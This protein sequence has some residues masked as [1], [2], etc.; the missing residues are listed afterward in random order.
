M[1]SLGAN[2][3][4]KDGS[5]MQANTEV[6]AGARSH[7]LANPRPHSVLINTA[8]DLGATSCRSVRGAI[9]ASAFTNRWPPSA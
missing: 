3:A 9:R 2:S 6:P 5:A 1:D 4:T 8:F 7:S